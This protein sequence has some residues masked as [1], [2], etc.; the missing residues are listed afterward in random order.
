MRFHLPNLTGKRVLIKPKDYLKWE[1]SF[2]PPPSIL[3]ISYPDVVLYDDGSCRGCLSTLL[4]FLREYH[5][6]LQDYYLTDKKVHIGIGK[7]LKTCPEGIILIGN[8]TAR[9]RRGGIFVQVCPPVSSQIMRALS[10]RKRALSSS[11]S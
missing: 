6:Q 9:V 8:C 4:V 7:H 1:V 2:E 11:P 5:P 3:S 10:Q